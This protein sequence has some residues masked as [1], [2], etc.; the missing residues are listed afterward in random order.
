M[1]KALPKGGPIEPGPVKN[2]MD[3]MRA[4]REASVLCN[5]GKNVKETA[6]ELEKY[7][8]GS[9]AAIVAAVGGVILTSQF[10]PP[11]TFKVGDGVKIKTD[12]NV[13]GT[14]INEWNGK[15]LQPISKTLHWVKTEHNE[16]VLWDEAQI[17]KVPPGSLF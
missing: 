8:I 11:E 2:H 9:E 12:G 6:Q 17:R 10:K 5:E 16:L 3:A 7:G 13:Y 1:S 15:T 4:I 14:I